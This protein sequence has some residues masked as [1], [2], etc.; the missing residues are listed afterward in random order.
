MLDVL[1][2]GAGPAGSALAA[3]LLQRGVTSFA[4][5]E[6]YAFPRDKPC[7]GGLTGHADEAFAQ[8]DLALRVPHVASTS[9][10]VRMGAF[11]RQ[12]PMQ[13]PVRVIRRVD[14]DAD[15]VA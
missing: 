3:R 7:G 6:R 15:L 13:R 2:I 12:V 10:T 1:V 9:A 4:V 5:L 14:F 11:T 8:L